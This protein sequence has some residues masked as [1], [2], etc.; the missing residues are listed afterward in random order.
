LHDLLGKEILHQ[1]TYTSSTLI[2]TEQLLPGI[3]LLNYFLKE[4]SVHLKLA[5]F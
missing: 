3:Y 2:N 4:K 5:K 1:K